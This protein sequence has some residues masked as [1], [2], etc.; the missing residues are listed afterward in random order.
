[1]GAEVAEHNLGSIKVLER[2]GFQRV[3]LKHEG[4]VDLFVMR[5][6]ATV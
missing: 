2:C 1:L 5:L 3:G 4:D 6:E